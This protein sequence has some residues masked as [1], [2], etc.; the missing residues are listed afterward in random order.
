MSE[1]A[2]SEV[3][4]SDTE[5]CDVCGFA[6][7]LVDAADVP[8]RVTAAADAAAAVLRDIQHE[9]AHRHADPDTWS[10]VEYGCHVRDV[11]YNVRDRIIAGVAESGCAPRP[12]SPGVRV[13][14][15]MYAADEPAT[16]AT[17]L[18][19]AGRLFARTVRVLTP[20]QRANTILYAW[21][22]ETQRS[23]AWVA[24]Q[25]LHEAEHHLD[26]ILRLAATA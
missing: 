7:D 12:M 9:P 22:R 20:E 8:D 23:L 17:E 25:A 11:L 13:G 21:P 16:L 5:R 1:I 18:E 15:G 26:D 3:A 14:T 4:R 10:L 19:L 24:A 2:G 6:W